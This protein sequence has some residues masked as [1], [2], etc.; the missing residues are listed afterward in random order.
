M[1]ALNFTVL[2]KHVSHQARTA[3]M[4]IT[5]LCCLSHGNTGLTQGAQNDDRTGNRLGWDCGPSYSYL[6]ATTW[7]LLT[8]ITGSILA[9]LEMLLEQS[10]SHYVRTCLSI[11]VKVI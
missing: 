1:Y 8:V 5:K 6:G 7:T 10:L 4:T 2:A 9:R 3:L 11:T